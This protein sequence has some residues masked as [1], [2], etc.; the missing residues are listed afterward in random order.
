MMQTK[1]LIII[2]ISLLVVMILMVIFILTTEKQIP[3][4]FVNN[5]LELE[6]KFDNEGIY[7][8][9]DSVSKI[10][11]IWIK[12]Y[13][14][15][16]SCYEKIW[17]VV[18]YFNEDVELIERKKTNSR[19]SV[20]DKIK[21]KLPPES[22]LPIAILYS[23]NQAEVKDVLSIISGESAC[24][25]KGMMISICRY[26]NN[27]PDICLDFKDKYV[28]VDLGLQPFNS[29]CYRSCNLEYSFE[30]Y[31]INT[32]WKG[33]PC[34]ALATYV[35]GRSR[36]VS[37]NCFEKNSC[38]NEE[39]DKGCCNGIECVYEGLC[40]SEGKS[41][42]V[43]NDG[44][45]EVCVN[46]DGSG[47]WVN[48][49]YR[50]EVC[51]VRFDWIDC[52]E[53]DCEGGKDDYD[54]KYNGMCCGDDKGEAYLS[55]EGFVCNKSISNDVSC[56]DEGSCVYNKKCYS[57]GCNK[58]KL[59]SGE[60]V[61]AYCK[62]GVWIDIDEEFCVTCLG[63]DSWSGSI[64]CG[65]DPGE[66]SFYNTLIV[67][68]D[69]KFENEFVEYCTHKKKTCGVPDI[70]E[71]FSEGC[72][73]FNKNQYLKGSYY[74]HEKEWYDLDNSTEYCDKCGFTWDVSSCCGDD[75]YEYFIQG[76][77]GTYA[78]CSYENDI[79]RKGTCI[80]GV[81]CG[82][83]IVESDEECEPPYSTDN[84]FCVQE[85]EKCFGNFLGT[86]DM[87][88][89]CGLNC[90]CVEDS[91]NIQ[92]YK[93]KCGA[94]CSDNSDCGNNGFCD[95][96]TCLCINSTFCGD[97]VVQ[98]INSEGIIEECELPGTL[99][100]SYCNETNTCFDKSTGIRYE[101]GSCNS[102]CKCEYLDY[103]KQCIKGSCGAECNEDGTGCAKDYICNIEECTCV[104]GELICG[105]G[106][107]ENNEQYFCPQDCTLSRCPFRIDIDT[108]K[109]YYSSDDLINA[110]VKIYNPS[111]ELMSFIPFE[112]D[113]FVNNNYIRSLTYNTK[114]NGIYE[115]YRKPVATFET[116]KFEYTTY[117]VRTDIKDCSDVGDEIRF[118]VYSKEQPGIPVNLSRYELVF[119][120]DIDTEGSE[121]GNAILEEGESCE[122]LSICRLTQGCDYE[123]RIH[124]LNEL[125]Y[126]CNCPSDMWSQP[127]DY[128]YCSNCEG[129]CGD[130]VLNCN[131][132]CEGETVSSD[133]VCKDNKLYGQVDSC[134]DCRIVDDG[135]DQDVLVD[136]CYC[137]CSLSLNECINGDWIEYPESYYAGCSYGQCNEC[138]CDDVYV[139]DS[140]R[141]DVEDKCSPEICNNL[142]D[143]N[144]NGL[145]DMKDPECQICENCGIGTFNL[146]DKE[147]CLGF[148][149]VCYF[150]FTVG[151]YGTCYSC[152]TTPYCEVYST[153]KDFCYSNPCFFQDC[154]WTGNQCCTDED[155]DEV[156]DYVDN[157]PRI[158]NP[159][160]E[161][162][163][164][165]NYG[166]ECDV[167]V[168]EPLLHE[169]QGNNETNC[170][171]L[172]DNDC[173]TLIDLDDEDCLNVKDEI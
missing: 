31:N 147:E 125:C 144:D 40:Y 130:G 74:C 123:K 59:S 95:T 155:K 99:L 148:D 8:N 154:I 152:E 28:L 120:E 139:K 115:L 105:D 16:E 134:I 111:N 90:G 136:D 57:S 6:S 65:D 78:C 173:D 52:L 53:F 138:V 29:E 15:Y 89:N 129:H 80:G 118:F 160:Q 88:G 101:I 137:E 34:D 42:D 21:F 84:P 108:N 68:G 94:V 117:V 96:N 72:Y 44:Q 124:D 114:D 102:R 60:K 56:C 51:N 126:E 46:V 66:G 19:K 131:E 119:E 169:P 109:K 121:C 37:R 170:F 104:V 142:R 107:C 11:K 63:H 58:I 83:E 151:K 91:Y 92:C 82:D 141:D 49:D 165:D 113:I 50:S 158:Y 157:C 122:G 145:I 77:D 62:E 1:K 30:H 116:G 156:C 9:V 93:G 97:G 71:G 76:D 86:R 98:E 10:D 54:Q 22:E 67:N 24:S 75:D 35:E 55:C 153:N 45:K 4:K 13:Y 5:I 73:M 161:D 20:D 159:K 27:P 132:A 140:N 143:D 167:C 163:D 171:D 48:P 85:N 61:T 133:F 33:Y 128:M 69:S 149:S 25:S 146:C 7:S 87:Y 41:V 166:D 39:Q 26:L 164:F 3:E 135:I 43:E 172:I 110:T 12:Y 64:C 36:V 38:K 2:G 112:L 70:N 106:I 150:E 17:K 32:F 127:D 100:N 162:F 168:E 47:S 18:P 79:V 103:H 23:S 14:N 81:E